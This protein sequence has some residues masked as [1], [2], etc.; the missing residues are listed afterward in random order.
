MNRSI[1]AFIIDSSALK[2]IFEGKNKGKSNDL[3]EQ[4]IR[5]K[6][7]GKQVTAITTL[8]SFLRAIY[9]TDPQ[10]DINKTQKTL[11]FLQVAP[12]FA[13]FKKEKKDI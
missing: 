10:V 13:D 9:L 1:P 7:E 3:L 11:S 2:D 8:S 4:L 12:S 6:D 5:L